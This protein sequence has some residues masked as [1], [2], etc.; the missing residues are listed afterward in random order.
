MRHIDGV[1][2]QRFNKR[3]K[4]DGSLFRGRYKSIIIGGD[5]Y[6]KKL[7]QYIHMN[8]VKAGISKKPEDH[9]WTSHRIYLGKEKQNWL[10]IDFLLSQFG[11]RRKAALRHLD[12]YVKTNEENE[13]NEK[14]ARVRW[15][16]VLGGDEFKEKLRGYISGEPLNKE[17]IWQYRE[18]EKELTGDD[19]V[20][21]LEQQCNISR[22][23]IFSNCK[24][25][26][27]RVYIYLA[28]CYASKRG[29][30]IADELG[31]IGYKAVSW[32][33]K[34]AINDIS[35]KKGCWGIINRAENYLQSLI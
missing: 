15:P 17:E 22:D 12:T 33:Y 14:L 2:T 31:D 21:I 10:K 9:K 7:L 18:V 5:N 20:R 34:Q 23:T 27:R 1:Y 6:L 24:S 11:K 13:L 26:G 8:P 29:K 16:A 32:H 30:E 3:H 19:I 25:P 35:A 28:K 4:L